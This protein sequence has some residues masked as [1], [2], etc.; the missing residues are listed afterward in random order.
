MRLFRKI[1]PF[2]SLLCCLSVFVGSVIYADSVTIVG[3]WETTDHKTHQPSSVIRIWERSG[4]YFGKI[5][6]IYRENN[7]K[8]ADRCTQCRGKLQNK[9]ILGM[10][11]IQDLVAYRDAY[12]QGMILDPRDGKFY[13]CQMTVVDRGQ[14]L[15]V[16]GYIGFPLLG[17]TD[18]W[19]RVR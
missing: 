3:N 1:R 2:F 16:R 12:R 5:V 7:Q 17:R 4:K 8:A 13:H 18:I 19:L 10:T 15:K 11:I 6:K 14:R 9:P